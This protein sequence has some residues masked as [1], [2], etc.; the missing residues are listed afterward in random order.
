MLAFVSSCHAAG[1]EVLYPSSAEISRM[2]AG[3]WSP[4]CDNLEGMKI[5]D[6]SKVEFTINSN[7]I[8]IN[9]TLQ[10]YSKNDGIVDVYFDSPLDLGRG[11]MKL[12]WVNFSKIRQI[13]TI[14]IKD[15]DDFILNWTGFFNKKMKKYQWVGQPDFYRESG[16][17]DFKRCEN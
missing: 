9:S 8:V 6:H 14:K 13:A 5:G 11:G 3:R 4:N 15:E 10:K 7:Q 12:D 1:D 16:M 2:L 17:I